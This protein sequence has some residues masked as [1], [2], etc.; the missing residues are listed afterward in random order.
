MYNYQ[1][2]DTYIPSIS[3]CIYEHNYYTCYISPIQQLHSYMCNHIKAIRACFYQE[4]F[5]VLL[6]TYLQ[7]INFNNLV[8]HFESLIIAIFPILF[9][10]Y[11]QSGRLP[12]LPPS[13][14]PSLPPILPSLFFL[15]LQFTSHLILFSFPPPTSDL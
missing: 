2:L 4:S 6:K 10:L 14:L 9:L 5:K 11:H 3:K 7:Y 12:S 15:Y 8:L 1:Y 13:L